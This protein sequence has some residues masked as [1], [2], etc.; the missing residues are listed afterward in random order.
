[1]EVKTEIQFIFLI[2]STCFII[3]LK[4]IFFISQKIMFSVFI[5][6]AGPA[7]RFPRITYNTIKYNVIN[8]EISAE[9]AFSNCGEFNDKSLHAKCC[10]VCPLKLGLSVWCRGFP[11]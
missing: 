8:F 11:A 1:M 3:I 4:D 7:T 9:L 2:R 5:L 6:C 10:Y